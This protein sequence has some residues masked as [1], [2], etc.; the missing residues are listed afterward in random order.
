MGASFCLP[1]S[2][3]KA[4]DNILVLSL[5]QGEGTTV[6]RCWFARVR[7]V[8]MTVAPNENGPESFLAL[9]AAK[10]GSLALGVPWGEG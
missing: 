5:P 3:K 4:I 9:D 7:S 10:D 1:T 2:S 8:W 6:C